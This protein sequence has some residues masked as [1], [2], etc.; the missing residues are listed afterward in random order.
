MHSYRYR[1]RGW[2]LYH[3]FALLLSPTNYNED[4][5]LRKCDNLIRRR[6]LCIHMHVCPPPP[7]IVC[8]YQHIHNTVSLLNLP[9]LLSSW[10]WSGR[11]ADA[12]TTGAVSAVSYSPSGNQ[13]I[14]NVI[15]KLWHNQK[16]WTWVYSISNE[17][18]E[19][20]LLPTNHRLIESTKSRCTIE[21][22][23]KLL[24]SFRANRSFAWGLTFYPVNLFLINQ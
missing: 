18:S 19:S 12:A 17:L 21:T 15:L 7:A 5:N 8:T 22:F 1:T 4:S 16:L 20:K 3:D 24:P 14:V 10:S 11:V 6:K 2:K 13:Q 9:S 23:F